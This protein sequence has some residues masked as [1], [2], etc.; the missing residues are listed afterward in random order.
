MAEDRLGLGELL[1]AAEDAA[2]A[3]SV[4]VVARNLR[5]RFDAQLVSFL[6]VDVIGQKVVRLE[7]GSG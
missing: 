4:D 6:F 1:A 2:P 3:A 5:E 7:A